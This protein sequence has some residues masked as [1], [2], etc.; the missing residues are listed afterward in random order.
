MTKY[1]LQLYICTAAFFCFYM[2]SKFVQ[3]Q[4][5]YIRP[6]T[7]VGAARTHKIFDAGTKYLSGTDNQLKVF[8]GPC[9]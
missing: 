3:S 1:V 7:V 2:L 5:P 6:V 4:C 8:L 9:W